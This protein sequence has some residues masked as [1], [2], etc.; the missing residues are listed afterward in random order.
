M[1]IIATL[2]PNAAHLNRLR[3][4][5][6][7]R[8][9]LIACEDW[10]ELVRAA[11]RQPVRLAIV[12]LFAGEHANFE[13]VRYVKQRLP[14]LT[15]I[16]YVTFSPDRAHDVFDAGRQGMD[17]LIIADQDDSPRALLALVEQ[18]E[19]KSLGSVVRHSLAGVEMTARDAVL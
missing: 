16:A 7:D 5:I 14:R 19:S 15:L 17:G 9:Q 4:A 13:R 12:D 11:E 1:G 3:T 18:A 10:A 2:L 6:R 8:H